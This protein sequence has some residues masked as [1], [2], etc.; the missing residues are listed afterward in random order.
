MEVLER[1]HHPAPT[2]AQVATIGQ[3]PRSLNSPSKVEHA[4]TWGGAEVLCAVFI[5]IN[6][7]SLPEDNRTRIAVERQYIRINKQATILFSSAHPSS[8]YSFCSWI[9]KQ[10]R[11]RADPFLS[12]CGARGK[13]TISPTNSAPTPQTSQIDSTHH[14]LTLLIN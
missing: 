6:K 4:G 7:V 1:L 14:I 11:E 9:L 3:Q 10:S 12:V 13:N 2:H 5:N 8:T